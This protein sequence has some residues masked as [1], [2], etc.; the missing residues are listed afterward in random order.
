MHKVMLKKINFD[1]SDI[2][3]HGLRN[4]ESAVD[5]EFCIPASEQILHEVMSIDPGIR[6]MKNSKGR[7]GCTS[8]QW[9]CINSTHRDEWKKKLFA[10]SYLDDV[11]R[12]IE[13]FYE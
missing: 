6:V 1:Y 4:G 13:T 12:I 10:I 3:E 2:D 5:Y 11:D 7:I 9:L 8:Q